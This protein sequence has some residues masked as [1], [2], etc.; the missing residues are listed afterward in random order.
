MK[1]I[2]I[3]FFAA[4]CGMSSFGISELSFGEP[5]TLANHLLTVNAEWRYHSGILAG[6]QNVEL[7]SS[8]TE[9]IAT[10]LNTVIALI[11]KKTHENGEQREIRTLLMNQLEAYVVM[12]EFPE[13]R[14]KPYR[15]PVF[16]DHRGVH[17]AV[18]YLMLMNGFGDLARNISERDNLIRVRDIPAEMLTEWVA[19]CGLT[20]EEMALIQPGYLPPYAWTSYGEPFSGEVN[21]ILTYNGTVYITGDF[22]F[23]NEQ[24]A[25]AKLVD[26]V[27]QPVEGVSGIGNKLEIYG[28]HLWIAG[29]F[30]N[31]DF[32]EIDENDSVILRETG[33]SKAPVG[34]TLLAH[35]NFLYIAHDASGFVPMSAIQRW[36]GEQFELI[37]TG[38]SATYALEWHNGKLYAAG[39]VNNIYD[40]EGIP[41]SVASWDGQMWQQAGDGIPYSVFDLLSNEGTLWA[42]GQVIEGSAPAFGYARMDGE[43]WLSPPLTSWTS[44]FYGHILEA[45]NDQIVL[46]IAFRG[47]ET[48][49]NGVLIH[50]SVPVWNMMVLG[51]LVMP[52]NPDPSLELLWAYQLSSPVLP[53]TQNHV[54][55]NA[56]HFDGQKLWAGGNFGNSGLSDLKRIASSDDFISSVGDLSVETRMEVFPNPASDN[57]TVLFQQGEFSRLTIYNTKGQAVNSQQIDMEMNRA[58]IER[59]ALPSGVYLIQME[60]QNPV[61]KSLIIL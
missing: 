16:I 40:A 53:V 20:L 56:L 12:S 45:L 39:E 5:A 9:R 48:T 26:G 3:L 59:A 29:Q 25:L 18:G 15:V 17:C 24:T 60:G 38:E 11:R 2:A 7:F 27:F 52:F 43:I 37:G 35:E 54:S 44:L 23:D 47:F 6:R 31:F 58:F 10:H 32:A 51:S 19:F 13:N 49:E 55:T 28:G 4:L 46:D 30:G 61:R 8:D 57:F 41:L 1:Q 50:G 42:C 34:Y 36:N 21:D 14:A 22:S 33:L